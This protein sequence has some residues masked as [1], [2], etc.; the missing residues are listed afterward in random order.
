M[1]TGAVTSIPC[2]LSTTTSC[3]EVVTLG[4]VS[5]NPGGEPEFECVPLIEKSLVMG[6]SLVKLNGDFFLVLNSKKFWVLP[7]AWLLLRKEVSCLRK[8][9]RRSKHAHSLSE[10][11]GF[12]HPP[13]YAMRRQKRIEC[14]SVEETA[15]L[16]K[17]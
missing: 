9:F 13:L 7:M 15:L 10:S 16:P 5:F 17:D 8:W 14:P 11:L 3:Q 4:D 1:G 6:V 12:S 2:G